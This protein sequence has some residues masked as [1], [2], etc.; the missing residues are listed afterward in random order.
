MGSSIDLK[1][2]TL[3]I[4]I[5]LSRLIISTQKLLFTKYYSCREPKSKSK[6][7]KSTFWMQGN[8]MLRV[9]LIDLKYENLGQTIVRKTNICKYYS[10]S[11]VNYKPGEGQIQFTLLLQLCDPVARLCLIF[12]IISIFISRT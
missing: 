9:T 12:R 4:Y 3:D 5:K 10:F 7:Y 8:I 2:P 6:V 1:M 11:T